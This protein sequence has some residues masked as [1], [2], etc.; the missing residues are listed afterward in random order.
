MKVSLL[1][2]FAA[3]TAFTYWLRHINLRHL[4]QYGATV[5]DGFADAISQETLAKTS[6]YTIDSSRLGLWESL[7]DNTLLILFLFAGLLPMYDRF[8]AGMSDSFIVQ[9]LLFFLILTWTQAILELPFTLYST[10]VV[11]ARHGFNTSTLRIWAADLLKS[12]VIGSILLA[13]IISVSLWLI[14]WSPLHWWLWLWGVMAMFTLVMMFLSPYVIEPLFNKFEP[15]DEPGLTEEIAAMMGKAG[16]KVGRVMKMDA[17]KRSRHSNA[18][19][20]GI[21]KVKRI[22]LFDTLIE[23]MTHAEIVAVL[24]HEIG[25]WKL[26]HILKRLVVAEGMLLGGMWC[27]WQAVRWEGLTG[28]VGME[29]G[30]FFAR[31]MILGFIAS[32]LMFPFTPLSAW[33]SRRHEREADRFACAITGDPESLA[34]ALIKLSAENLSNLHPHP[35]YA[36]F[37]YSHPPVVE[38]VRSLR[39]LNA[40]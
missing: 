38:R 3:T 8:V 29:G 12:Q 23:Q 16:L 9:G 39:Q 34:S 27:A 37:Y 40:P 25:H 22:V 26:R 2:L 5:P 24:A 7:F 4:K 18:Y 11:E 33:L 19:F 13:L 28:L 36:G 15:V 21:G 20:T 6:A 32:L 1:L 35:L 17:S 30:S 31:L 14:E 10:F